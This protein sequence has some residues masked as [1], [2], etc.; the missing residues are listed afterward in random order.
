MKFSY[1]REFVVLGKVGEFQAAAKEL[2][3]MQSTLSKH[4]KS[5][6]EELGVLLFNR[7]NHKATLSELGATFLP[8]ARQLVELEDEYTESLSTKP[9]GA[10][11]FVI[12]LS[13]SV[14]QYEV[15]DLLIRFKGENQNICVVFREDDSGILRELVRS[16]ECDFA[17]IRENNEDE[18]PD[19]YKL[20]FAC[21]ALIAALPKDHPL[22][23]YPVIAMQQLKDEEFILLKEQ[24]PVYQLCISECKKAGFEPNIIYTGTSGSALI[25]LVGR[26][27]GVS[28]TLKTPKRFKKMQQVAYVDITPRA[29]SYVNLIYRR[30]NYDPS[31]HTFL[32]FIKP[33]M[34]YD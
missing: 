14:L 20:Q 1:L 33:Y 29:L 9:S 5:L 6:E 15:M 16:G 2:S 34:G 12:G 25:D 21:D 30:D 23:A 19:F 27:L 13:P 28:L 31:V 10:S 18:D 7:S 11:K 17:F 8:Y 26:G 4:I 24:S 3:I 22:A 32:R